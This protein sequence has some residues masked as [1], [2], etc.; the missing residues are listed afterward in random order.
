M[1]S[2][3]KSALIVIFINQCLYGIVSFILWDWVWLCSIDEWHMFSR[4]IFAMVIGTTLVIP[5]TMGLKDS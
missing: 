2:K 3:L 5:L 4:F 1:K